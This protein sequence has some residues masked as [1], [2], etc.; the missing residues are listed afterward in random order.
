MFK[1]NVEQNNVPVFGSFESGQDLPEKRMNKESV[2]PR[3][4][5][6]LV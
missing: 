5:Y 2:D 1:T 4:A 6:Q 3:I